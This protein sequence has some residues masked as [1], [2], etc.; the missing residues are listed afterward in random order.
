MRSI[1][2]RRTNAGLSFRESDS[3][4]TEIPLLI[5]SCLPLRGAELME[6]QTAQVNSVMANYYARQPLQS[7]EK[8]APVAAPH[9][10]VYSGYQT[11][12]PRESTVLLDEVPPR[13]HRSRTRKFIVRTVH[14]LMLVAVFVMLF[15]SFLRGIAHLSRAVSVSFL[16]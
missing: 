11:V 8:N 4:G 15:P 14:T 5:L 16:S 13:R 6:Q 9:V 7:G 12:S 1:D 10:A 2:C 3:E